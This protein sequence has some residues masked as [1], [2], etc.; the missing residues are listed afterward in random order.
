MTKGLLVGNNKCLS[1]D[2]MPSSKLDPNYQKA[3]HA[4]VI[5]LIVAAIITPT[6]DVFTLSLVSLPMWLLY[7]A[8]IWIVAKANTA[9]K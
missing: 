5:I 6:S 7:E 4:I 8:S 3:R 1:E 2:N 9:K